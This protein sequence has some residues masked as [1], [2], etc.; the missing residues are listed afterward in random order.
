M[1]NDGRSD[2][3]LGYLL[4][5]AHNLEGVKNMSKTLAER[6]KYR[7]IVGVW[8]SMFDK[9]LTGTLGS[10]MPLLDD[11]IL[12]QPYGER[13]ATPEAIFSLLTKEQQS[14]TQKIY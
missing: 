8:G 1:S 5:G 13:S 7:R 9:D 2:T 10:I 3:P 4:D 14:K 12:T 6:F 11:C